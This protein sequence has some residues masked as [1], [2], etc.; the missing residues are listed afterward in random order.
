MKTVF[1]DIEAGGLKG[2]FDQVY[3]AAFKPY[4]EEPY[5]LSRNVSDRADKELCCEIRDELAKYDIVVTYYG[6]NYDKPFLNSRLLK[7]GE[8]PLPRQLHIDCYRLAKKIFKY[9]L[10]SKRLV[11]IC[12]LLGIKG[13]TRVEP[14]IWET[15]KYGDTNEKAR[16]LKKV[17]E[18]CTWD[19]ITL[20]KAF[21]KCF[22]H[23]I[24]SVS[25]A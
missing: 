12:E 16:A 1:F 11:S 17:R 13:K 20:E 18:H 9:A 25:L 22:K 14:D 23:G 4:G 10:V 24:V 6:L 5:V 7:Q 3:C 21:D 8:R 15:M 19:V 2:E